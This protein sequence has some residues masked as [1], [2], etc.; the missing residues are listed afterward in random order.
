MKRLEVDGKYYRMRKGRLVEIPSEWVGNTLHPQ[1]K[2]KR[3]KGKNEVRNPLK[4]GTY[5]TRNYRRDKH[6][7]KMLDFDVV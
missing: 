5:P 7:L 1:T 6:L 4:D 3:R 2:R